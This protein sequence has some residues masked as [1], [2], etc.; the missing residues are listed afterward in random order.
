[1]ADAEGRE[2]LRA[3]AIL[4]I[5]HGRQV[6]GCLHV[7]SRTLPEV[8]AY[9]RLALETIAGQS[10][11]AIVRLRA[12]QALRQSEE[13]FRS[14][15][16]NALVGMFR[17]RLDGSE[18]LDANEKFLEIFGRTR[19]EMLGLPSVVHWADLQERQ[20]VLGRL[21]TQGRVTDFECR[22]LNKRGE[23]LT[24]L[25][26]L[27]L[28]REQGILEGSI[29][30]ITDRKRAEEALKQSERRNSETLEFN[31]RIL[32]TS[33][34]GILTFRESGPC[35]FANEAAAKTGGTDVASLLAQNFHEVPS[36]KKSG[37]YQAA[38]RALDTGIEQVL[39]TPSVTTFG[40]KV[41][42][43]FSFSSFDSGGERQLLVFARDVTDQ[44]R[45][46]EALQQSEQQFRAVAE[47]TCDLEC[48]VGTDGRL[49]W[50]NPAVEGLTGY[51]VEE[52]L[53]MPDFPAPFLHEEDKARM[54]D[55][56]RQ[57]VAGSSGRDVEYRILHKNGPVTWL[58]VSWQPIYALDGTCLG[59]RSSHRD[60]TERKR[61][62]EGL[63]ESEEKFRSLFRAAPVAVFRAR[64]DGTEL[65]DVND[66]LLQIFGRTRE[67]MVGRPTTLFWADPR[68]RQEMVR[69]LQ[70]EGRVTDFECRLRSKWGEART[71]L[72]SVTPYVHPGTIVGSLE[73]VTELRRMEQEVEERRTE[74]LHV[75]RLS[76][77][78]EMAAGIAHEL[79]QP[80]A[81]IVGYGDWCLHL[82]ESSALDVPTIRKN[83]EE[84]AAQAMRASEIIRGMKVLAGRRAPCLTSVDVNQAVRDVI[85]LIRSDLVDQAVQWEL[86][87]QEPLPSVCADKIQIEQVL[88]NLMRNAVEA[89]E[90]A[91]DRPGLLT[92]RTR[93][94]AGNVLQVEVRDTGVGLSANEIERVFEPFFTTKPEGLGMGLAIC[95]S[96]IQMY[97]GR[98]WAEPGPGRGCAFRFTL[99]T[100][101][102]RPRTPR[103]TA[104][105]TL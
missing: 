33:S 16:N 67:E 13:K 94:G 62:E 71:C 65:L 83:M 105:E 36:W 5:L 75:S 92:V 68:E 100:D 42:V 69:R 48:W 61:A 41:W 3:I 34:I 93:V 30:D 81:A 72:M 4:P 26:S 57:A 58:S 70:A 39:E 32:G 49:I 98:I 28:Y 8:P 56:H 52:C 54:L 103:E 10:S 31:K 97:K 18:I 29:R 51:T 9:A 40:K 46:I 63:R 90:S 80:L 22:M 89:M 37:M 23:V 27:T 91:P 53:A 25:I 21:E 50:V 59:H 55:L 77:L 78:G 76:T 82:L 14:L 99:P 74:L 11:G 15:F 66:K 88:L 6:I 101:P 79:N 102:E 7:A 87:L 104:E 73:D 19:E 2:G 38:I 17:T 85:P 20:E 45:A 84:I 47:Y 24:C 60:I 64:L 12:E 44:R 96:I 86:D 1:L 35:T 95:R 43:S